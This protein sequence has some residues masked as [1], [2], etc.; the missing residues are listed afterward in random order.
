L[1]QW[2]AGYISIGFIRRRGPVRMSLRPF[3]APQFKH[4]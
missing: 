4:Q 3:K 2:P 1:A